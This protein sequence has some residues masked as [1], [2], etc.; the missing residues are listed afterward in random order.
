M[1]DTSD[2]RAGDEHGHEERGEATEE[3]LVPFSPII[4]GVFPDQDTQILQT[5]ANTRELPAK[6]DALEQQ[7]QQLAQELATVQTNLRGVGEKVTFRGH[8][9]AV[10]VGTVASLGSRASG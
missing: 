7:V 6:V 10:M 8:P 9:V 3:E 5:W 1:G 4:P 2:E